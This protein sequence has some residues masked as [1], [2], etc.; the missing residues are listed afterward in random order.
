[1]KRLLFIATM[2]L[3]G[4]VLAQNQAPVRAAALG[5]V[6][7]AGATST[8]GAQWKQKTEYQ[9]DD[10]VLDVDLVRPDELSVDARPPGKPSSLIRIRDTFILQMLATADNI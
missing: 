8:E 2:S 1:M 10:D 3:A 4:P 7:A 6:G 9:F 5:S